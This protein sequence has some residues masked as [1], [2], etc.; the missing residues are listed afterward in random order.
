M[1]LA[2]FRSYL[3]L[4]ALLLSACDKP[5]QTTPRVDALEKKISDLEQRIK[6]EEHET[7]QLHLDSFKLRLDLQERIEAL[8]ERTATI[9]LNSTGYS[10]LDTGGGVILISCHGAEPYLNGHRI[11]LRLGNPLNMRFSGFKLKF[12]FGR[13]PPNPPTIK[14]MNGSDFLKAGEAWKRDYDAWKESLRSAEGSYTVDL[15]PG[16]W[17]TV[18]ATLPQTIAADIAYVEVRIETDIISLRAP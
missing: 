4:I 15:S 5:P 6:S 18:Q 1:N 10:F 14:G 17:K 13:K 2:S 11:K 8:K 7:F 3:T 12:K 9:D 16:A